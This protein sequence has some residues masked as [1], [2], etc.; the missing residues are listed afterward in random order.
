MVWTHQNICPTIKDRF[1]YML[2]N[3]IKSYT[4]KIT[5][6]HTFKNNKD[7]GT[8]WPLNEENY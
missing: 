7:Y 6:E 8:D 4:I 1:G 3:I 5:L 2:K